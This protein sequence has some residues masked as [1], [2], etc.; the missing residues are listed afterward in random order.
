MKRTALAVALACLCLTAIAW[1]DEV[2][3][4]VKESRDPIGDERKDQGI[5]MVKR[6][7]SIGNAGIRYQQAVD[8]KHGDKL[9]QQ[10]YADYILGCEFPLWSWNW[11]L[12]YFLE[13]TVTRPNEPPFSATRGA[14]QEGIY[15]LQQG[16]RGVADMVWPLAGRDPAQAGRLAVRLVKPADDPNWMY[17]R[18]SLE[19]EP[20]ARITQV[21]MSSFPVTTSGPAERQ[22]WVETA[23]R[24]LQMSGSPEKLDPKTEWA[25]VLHNKYADEEGGALLVMEPEQISAATA[26]GTYPVS[27]TMTP[28]PARAVTVAMGYFWDTPYEKAVAQFKPQMADRLARLR[29]VDWTVPVDQ[30]QWDREQREVAE[31][32][33]LL[34]AT[35][36]SR[37]GWAELQQRGNAVLAE[38]KQPTP[39]PAAYRRFVLLIRDVEAFKD[40]LYEPAIH[41]LID[42][43]TN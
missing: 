10:R 33:K 1:S 17:L 34:P 43:A 25:L 18:L 40:K 36:P 27:I 38:L 3:V 29:A 15:P 14:L 30:P 28:T 19:G 6:S 32:L 8:A 16:V 4:T 37:Q 39:D 22:R 42:T 21:Q 31:I 24:G 12:E 9:V 2:A 41:A 23:A 35:D 5:E 20:E 7:L 13:V 26:Q 11:E